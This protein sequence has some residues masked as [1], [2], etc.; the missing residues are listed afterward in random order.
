MLTM[1]LEGLLLGLPKRP[2]GGRLQY[3]CAWRGSSD[4]AHRCRRVPL[5][6][7]TNVAKNS[8]DDRGITDQYSG[9]DREMRPKQE[10]LFGVG[11][12]QPIEVLGLDPSIFP[13][14]KITRERRRLAAALDCVHIIPPLHNVAFAQRAA[15]CQ[16]WYGDGRA[17][18]GARHRADWLSRIDLAGAGVRVEAVD[19]VGGGDPHVESVVRTRV[20]PVGLAPR[21]CC[22]VV[23]GFEPRS[24]PQ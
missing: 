12:C 1:T 9:G 13:R 7:C 18:E 14:V 24:G 22:R 5:F 17:R 16:G 19:A 2:D 10:I 11:S 8:A 21:R 23:R 15:Y 6:I 4:L 3:R 20:G